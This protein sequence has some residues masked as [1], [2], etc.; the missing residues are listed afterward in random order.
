MSDPLCFQSK[1][2]CE[3][4]VVNITV[5]DPAARAPLT[6]PSQ[7]SNK[8]GQYTRDIAHLHCG[9][10]ALWRTCIVAHVHCGAR[11]LWCTCIVVHVHCG[12]RALW[13]TCIVVH[14]HCGARALWRTCNLL[15]LNVA[16]EH[17]TL[18]VR[19]QV[20]SFHYV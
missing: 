2:A 9:T 14:V 3:D 15:Y 4:E 17:Y 20:G 8:P 12:A 10:R 1:S 7:L 6:D 18:S 5:T 11:A 13:C 16:D 19:H